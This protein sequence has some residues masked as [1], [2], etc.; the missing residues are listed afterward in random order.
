M[1]F[2]YYFKYFYFIAKNWNIKLAAFTV[3]HEIKGERKYHLNT[4]EIDRLHHEKIESENLTHASIYQASS[5][6]LVEMAFKYLED[7]KV[8][9]GLVDYGCGKGR[10]L[11]VAAYFG[12]KKITGIDFSRNLIL[13]AEA[14]LEKI[15]HLF[16]ETDFNVIC[17]DVVNY[18]IE[19]D[20][21]C[22]FFFNPFDEIIMLK[23]IKSI[24]S[25]LK[26]FPREVWVIYINPLH[27]E[28]FLSA[29]FE[30]EWNFKKMEYLEF[31]IL[32]KKEERYQFEN[33]TQ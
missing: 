6:Y 22:F 8:N 31:S 24:L 25:S 16:P 26:D 11:I 28:M 13:E 32:S 5:Y 23:V 4:V 1:K 17:D 12:F 9:Y 3:Y 33:D 19:K 29:G 21:N 15:T 14:N 7:E 27:K 30:E 20:K 18:K 2:L 10:V